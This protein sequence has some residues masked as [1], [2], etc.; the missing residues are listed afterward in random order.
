MVARLPTSGRRKITSPWDITVD[1]EKNLYITDTHYVY[2]FTTTGHCVQRV[3][4]VV[5]MSKVFGNYET[6]YL[7]I[8]HKDTDRQCTNL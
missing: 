3:V 2:K 5:T 8:H 1:S 7:A 4:D 6:M